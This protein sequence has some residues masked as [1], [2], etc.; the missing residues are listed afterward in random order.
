MSNTIPKKFTK[1][2]SLL[3][4]FLFIVQQTGFAAGGGTPADPIGRGVAQVAG[5][6]NIAG[7]LSNLHNSFVPDKFRPLHLRYISYDSLNN[8]FKLLL[9]KGD[10]KNPKTQDIESTTKDLLSYF[11]TGLA[12]PNDTFWVNL[13]PDSPNDI[14][15]PL[16]AQTDVGRILLESDLQLKKDTARFTSPETPEGKEYWDKLYQK[17]GELFG[18]ENITIPT[19]TRPWIVPDEIIIRESTDSA[20]VY[21][22]TLKVMLEQDYLK[23]DAT[24]SFKD[25]KQKELNDYSSQLIRE[26]ILPKLI[27]EIN[28]AK[29]YAPLRQVYYSLILAQWFKARNANK[30]TQYSRLIDRRDLSNLQSKTSYSVNTYFTAY[31]ENFAKGEYNLSEPIQTPF[32]QTVRSYFSGGISSF[33][34]NPGYTAALSQPIGSPNKNILSAEQPIPVDN[35]RNNLPLVEAKQGPN[36]EP[37]LTT[38]LNQAPSQNALRQERRQLAIEVL[39]GLV[40]D[41]QLAKLVDDMLDAIVE[42]HLVGGRNPDGSMRGYYTSAE[43]AE[44]ARILEPRMRELGITGQLARDIRR[45]LMEKWVTGDRPVLQIKIDESK[46]NKN[47]KEMSGLSAEMGDSFYRKIDSITTNDIEKTFIYRQII[48]EIGNDRTQF[49]IPMGVWERINYDLPED[50]PY[51]YQGKASKAQDILVIMDNQGKIEGMFLY[52]DWDYIYNSGERC[53][54]DLSEELGRTE[55]ERTKIRLLKN[56]I[57]ELLRKIDLRNCS[58]KER[59]E[60]REVVPYDLNTTKS[61]INNSMLLKWLFSLPGAERLSVS[62]FKLFVKRV[63]F[64][65]G[66]Y[67]SGHS[68][69]SGSLDVFTHEFAHHIESSLTPDIKTAWINFLKENYP[70]FVKIV[71]EGTHKGVYTALKGIYTDFSMEDKIIWSANEWFAFAIASLYYCDNMDAIEIEKLV[72][73]GILPEWMRPS[74]LGFK[75]NKVTELYY[76]TLSRCLAENGYVSESLDITDN[77]MR[78]RLVMDTA[79]KLE[80]ER[81]I[82]I[83]LRKFY[84]D[85]KTD[86]LLK[87]LKEEFR[88]SGLNFY[89]NEN[90]A[91]EGQVVAGQEGADAVGKTVSLAGLS[92][93]DPYV[94]FSAAGGTYKLDAASEIVIGDLHITVRVASDAWFDQNGLSGN[95]VVVAQKGKDGQVELTIVIR[96][97]VKG[98]AL[99]EALAHEFLAALAVA[100]AFSTDQ[101]LSSIHNWIE[102][103]TKA[104]TSVPISTLTEAQKNSIQASLSRGEAVVVAT[105]RRPAEAGAESSPVNDNKRFVDVLQNLSLLVSDQAPSIPDGWTYLAH[106]TNLTIEEWDNNPENPFTSRVLVVRDINENDLS[107]VSREQQQRYGGYTG[108]SGSVKRD[109]LSAEEYALR[110]KSLQIRVLFPLLTSEQRYAHLSSMIQYCWNRYGNHGHPYVKSGTKLIQIAHTKEDGLDIFYYAQENITKEL[111]D[112]WGIEQAGKQAEAGAEGRQEPGK[113][114]ESIPVVQLVKDVKVGR[115]SDGEEVPLGG[116]EKLFE[117]G[118]QRAHFLF[119]VQR[120]GQPDQDVIVTYCK[121]RFPEEQE[122]SFLKIND[123]KIFEEA[124]RIMV[125]CLVSAEDFFL[126]FTKKIDGININILDLKRQG[127]TLWPSPEGDFVGV[128]AN[129]YFKRLITAIKHNAPPTVME[130]ILLGIAA[131]MTHEIMHILNWTQ[132]SGP[133]S[134]IATHAVH[135]LYEP[136]LDGSY[137]RFFQNEINYYIE[138]AGLNGKIGDPYSNGVYRGM[139]LV[140][141]ALASINKTYADLLKRSSAGMFK[142]A[143]FNL[144]ERG[145]ST[146]EAGRVKEILLSKKGFDILAGHGHNEASFTDDLLD[147]VRTGSFEAKL[148]EFT[149]EIN[150]NFASGEGR[151]AKDN[152]TPPS[153]T[154]RPD[155]IDGSA[156]SPSI[157]NKGKPGGIDFRFLPIVTQSMDSLKVSIRAMPQ[158]SLQRIDLTQEWSDIERMV[159]GGIT[160]STERLKEYLAASCFKGN[161]DSDMDKIISCISDILRTEEETCCLTDPTLK[162]ILVVLGSG[163]SGEELRE[164]FSGII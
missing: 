121:H 15:D 111:L 7:Y 29:R 145:W 25:P 75:D 46:I 2:I 47:M 125:E 59:L 80:V 14:I 139:L 4:C 81:Y 22:A 120:E 26:R 64:L 144:L 58:I 51:R 156:G 101:E 143:L 69:I 114:Q 138:H 99:Q 157:P 38:S 130:R 90:H 149:T 74:A 93:I 73:L 8:N 78:K 146:Q 123:R 71:I 127:N 72:D 68:V 28:N 82:N 136:R 13:R 113:G 56:K 30:N 55:E 9:D 134:E 142:D 92:L 52:I 87:E 1:F 108:Y 132:G 62:K 50:S 48:G 3:L 65:G 137:K 126:P 148:E 106:N 60:W 135:F 104:G 107:T 98:E 105:E 66:E 21:K 97:S 91:A 84:G 155:G 117:K 154:S 86:S 61:M 128:N 89:I 118:E 96:A 63:G 151:A 153:S 110:N 57:E 163:R 45:A 31:K 116:Y 32:G 85:E 100:G 76:L 162:D 140:A 102:G 159:Q 37:I 109:D 44:K 94:S 41:A 11:F 35:N 5:E 12:L 36:G 42:A 103:L 39:K 160:P 79:T 141:I 67:L 164:V 131:G 19:L 147:S 23:G 24:Y 88:Y 34:Q 40:P 152:V 83:S 43:I 27:K 122:D 70:D 115:L 150:K 77:L 161:L 124:M 54:V 6:L 119:R 17:A 18:S 16:L 129:I 112:A 53:F 33:M 10:T 133:S 158:A 49:I 20:Y 95:G